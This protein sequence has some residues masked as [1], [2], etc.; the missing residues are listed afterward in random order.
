MGTKNSD[1]TVKYNLMCKIRIEGVVSQSDIVGALFGQTEGLLDSDMDLKQLQKSSRVGRIKLEIREISG[2]TKGKLIVPSSLNKVNTAILAATLESVDRVGPCA[3]S[4]TLDKIVDVR[5]AKRDIIQKRASEIMKK[6]DV[7]TREEVKH[8]SK[9]V[10]RE[11]N[12]GRVIIFGTDALP[13]GPEIYQ[14]TEIILVEGRADVINLMKMGINNTIALQGTSVP[15]TIKS[16]SKTR[17]ITALLDGDRGGDMILKELASMGKI[18]FVSRAPYKREVEDCSYNEIIKMIE[19][20]VPMHEANFVMEDQ[21]VSDY[22]ASTKVDYRTKKSTKFTGKQVVKQVTSDSRKDDR[23]SD[24]RKDD[25]RSDSRKDDRRSDSRK[26]DRRSDSKRDDRHSDSRKD[27]R[28]SSS[29]KFDGRTNSRGSDRHSDSRR[30][31]GSSKSRS[32]SLYNSKDD[33][34]R[35][36]DR[37]HFDR[38]K[39]R[40]PR[41]SVS[42]ALLNVIEK[43]KRTFN[44]VFVGVSNETLVTVK[45]SEVYDT[46]VSTDGVESIIMDGVITQRLLDLA[47]TKSVK[48][49]AGA[50]IG[51]IKNRPKDLQYITFNRI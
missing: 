42:Q 5:K 38:E 32:P 22:L 31:D 44:A 29:K 2:V 46:L 19:D 39:S 1:E 41:I 9:T 30:R 48:L 13:A 51:D 36:G 14:A 35:S 7:E 15:N 28:R 40:K 17:T 27:D 23:R 49:V 33:S 16:L 21:T 34:R 45:T 3:C 37:R 4:I 11:S 50:M 25:R 24:S 26:D 47:D 6:W 20:K 10:E 12:K 43:T 8:I 18:E